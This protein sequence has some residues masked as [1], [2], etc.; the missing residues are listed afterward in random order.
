MRIL[1]VDDRPL[2][3]RKLRDDILT[4]EPA[5]QVE[6]ATD[7]GRAADLARQIVQ[8]ATEH[9][10]VLLIDDN[11]GVGLN[12]SE[13]MA[14]LR[15]LSPNSE[16]IIFTARADEE[17]KRRAIE[18][19]ARAY[20]SRPIN[21]QELLWQLRGIQK[22]QSTRQERDW[23]KIM[24]EI[25]TQ[26]QMI[27]DVQQLADLIV[28]GGLRFGFQRARLRLFE[29]VGR[30][31]TSD[32]EMIGMSQ[33]GTPQLKGFENL[34]LPL[35]RLL[36]S[37]EAI[38]AGKPLVF[39][40]RELGPGGNDEFFAAHGMPLPQ[41]HW[42]KVPL[43]SDN[44]AIGTL[45][46]DN[47]AEGHI[48][49]PEICVQYIQA[50]GVF[51]A[52][53][54]S[55]LE[56]ARLHEQ[57]KVAAEEASL[58]SEISRQV[59]AVAARGDLNKLLDEVRRQVGGLMDATNFM[60]VLKDL[61][62]GDLDF[63]RAY[64]EGRDEPVDRHWRSSDAGLSGYVITKNVAVLT[65]DTD[66]FRKAHGIKLYGR[67]AACWLGVPLHVKEGDLDVAV[68][69]L[70]VQ[71][72]VDKTAYQEHHRNLL[73]LVAD[74]V[75][76]AIQMAYRLENEAQQ[77]RQE[78]AL[79]HLHSA[80]PR[81]IQES[82]DS[83]WHAV[84]TTVTHGDGIRFNRAALFWYDQ[85][86]EN[87]QGRMGIGYFTRSDARRTWEDDLR[88][89]RS[90]EQYI[91]APH[92]A[93]GRVTPL[94]QE[95]IDWRPDTGKPTGPCYRMWLEGTRQVMSSDSLQN[96]LPARLLQPP[97][98][99]DGASEYPC[100]LVPVKSDDKVMGLL[101]VDNAFDGKP[102]RSGD[103][104]KVDIVLA[105]AMRVWS[106]HQKASQAQQLGESY[107]QILALD[108]RLTAKA[109]EQTL[110]D[111]LQEL[112][113][114]AQALT[115]ADC[116]VAYPYHSSLGGYDLNL[117]SHVGLAQLEEFR[118]HTR[119]K[120]RQHGVTFTIVQSGTLAVPDVRT[121]NVAFGGRR[122]EEHTFLKREQIR[123]LIGTPMRQTAT[124]ESLGVI[125]LDYRAPQTFTELDLA[126]AEHLA[127]I[128]AKIISYH[129]ETERQ[130]LG[131]AEA[132]RS[133]QQLRRD[134]QILNKIQRLAL[135]GDSDEQKVIRAILM[136]AAD[137]FEQPVSITLAL[138]SWKAKGE[139]NR[140]VRY[141]WRLDKLGRLK[142]RR[143]KVNEGLIGNALGQNGSCIVRNS[144]AIPIHQ[145][146]MSVAA[147]MV[148]K[149][150]R[151][152]TFDAVEQEVAERLTTVASSA[153]DNVRTR[154][155][156]RAL[157]ETVG[158]ISD[159]K[160]LK[161][162]LRVVVD[163]ARMVAPDIDCVT[164]WYEDHEQKTLVA[165]PS[166]GVM[167]EEHRGPNLKT[168]HLVRAVMERHRPIFA[169]TVERESV[170]WGDFV[171]DEGI[172]SVAAFPLRFGEKPAAFGALFF[173]YRRAHE[174]TSLERTMF[175][176]FANAAATAIHSAQTIDQV[177]RRDKHLKMGLA[178]AVQ[179]SASLDRDEVLRGILVEL[180][181]YYRHNDEEGTLPYI[182][183]YDEQAKALVLPQIAREFYRPDRPEY[184]HRVHLRIDGQ[185]I[186]TR[187]ARR[188]RD[189]GKVVVDNVSNVHKDRDYVE[190]NSRTQSELC[191]GLVIEKNLLGALVI[192]SD[193]PEAFD[194]EDEQLV[195]MA[196]QQVTLV[197]DRLNR[198]VKARRDASV[199]GAMAWAA[200]IAHDINNDV[201]Y[202]R[203]RAYWL[204][205]GEPSISEEGKTWAREIDMR[206]KQL[207]DSVRDA[208]F[209][210]QEL[211]NFSLTELLHER[212]TAW[213]ATRAAHTEVQIAAT[214]AYTVRGDR[215]LLW[216]AIRHLLRN[217]RDA[218]EAAGSEH[219]RITLRLSSAHADHV[220][221]QIE[222][223]GPGVAEEARRR[224]LREPFS[225]K[226]GEGSGYGLLIAQ[227]LVESLGGSIYLYPSDPGRG[228]CFG[229]RLP[230]K[231]QEEHH[232]S[233]E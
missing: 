86:G 55:A 123:A 205:E 82:E 24:T 60:V 72:Y 170:L 163:R 26:M 30:E 48:F 153:L 191:A 97:D 45:T 64:D 17:G 140:Q 102:L 231:F 221:L 44:Y 228:A 180:S 131:V 147:L 208:R 152:A 29:Q 160:G 67:P 41:G 61:E 9:F 88:E 110:K 136:N 164:L 32:P 74:Q 47:G 80:L 189:A 63:R 139:Q 185:G 92:L 107:E 169:T 206:A 95:I 207:A 192:K 62:T 162:T 178:L 39:R 28:R 90:L 157:S 172:A 53:A 104:N 233:S 224:I 183:L 124:G 37:Q 4:A 166:F 148:K 155:Y 66:A 21:E 187:T 219:R 51:G 150:D 223:T 121:S 213:A 132:E 3:A 91:T 159:K 89:G 125:Y 70:A 14:E 99:L 179:A 201:G 165:G 11:L 33:A 194:W 71:D 56:R 83:F 35:S 186:T 154:T 199:A 15:Q 36:Y 115:H 195:T 18:T 200:D 137:L 138:L 171:Q 7:E 226:R 134:M 105:E 101:V 129:R 111:S 6:I 232:D 78:Q 13:L 135:A 204:R 40:D 203:N 220:E 142:S 218:I 69:V 103:L 229:I 59:T 182:M 100:A 19:G 168:D 156:L 57:A 146:E 174:F 175:P 181:E 38:N 161:D 120:P 31:A 2:G 151:R 214:D 215:E 130:K 87:M 222:D 54:A 188:A 77:R 94:Q 126:R 117:V 98:L 122:L 143:V 8:D 81:L 49:S 141:D 167:N 202:I 149:T 212:A 1:I 52:Q 85:S 109:A 217:A 114:E 16:A 144:L 68:G 96:S 216:R 46:L 108:H 184:E 177:E 27:N 116:V 210:R 112:C 197:L 227:W 5:Y 230:L 22:D 93:S 209:R 145:G 173:N 25:A 158:A 65:D 75:A 76:G 211:E 128:G 190:V 58:L 34:R 196:A 50:L 193:R 119:N 10:N 23:L 84:L 12:G 43:L 198:V 127:A 225:T 42:F 73:Q 176:I 133:E 113:R 20:V 79:Q 118:A 106:D